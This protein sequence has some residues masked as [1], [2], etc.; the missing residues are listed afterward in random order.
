MFVVLFSARPSL[1]TLVACC[2]RPMTLPMF[3]LRC[4]SKLY[5]CMYV[6]T[7][8]CMYACMCAFSVY[9]RE[10]GTMWQNGRFY[11]EEVLFGIPPWFCFFS[12]LFMHDGTFLVLH[13]LPPKIGFY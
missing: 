6:R 11:G 5:V 3:T 13:L 10:I 7:Y 12:L 4:C 2:F 8:V 9:M 1:T